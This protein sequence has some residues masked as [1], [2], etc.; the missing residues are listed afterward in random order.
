MLFCPFRAHMI[1]EVDLSPRAGSEVRGINLRKITTSEFEQISQLCFSRGVVVIRDQFLDANELGEFSKLWGQ[2]WLGPL[3]PALTGTEAVTTIKN[4]GKTGTVTEY[5]HSDSTFVENPPAVTMLSAVDVPMVGGDTMWCNQYS[6]YD[7]LS[8]G[9]KRLIHSLKAVHYDR[10][11]FNVVEGREPYLDSYAHPIVRLH[12][13]T[14]RRSL[15]ISGQAEHFEEMTVEESSGLLQ[16]LLSR[17]GQPDHVYRHRWRKGDVVIW[18]NRC[19]T[20]YAVHD[21]GQYPRQL[22]RITVEGEQPKMDLNPP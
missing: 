22:H 13:A 7:A 18:D 12:P 5:W 9:M 6:V 4:R 10:Q 20:H 16:Y 19:T 1:S 8:D 15:F 14:Q 3:L 17:L 11:R 21:Y 2:P